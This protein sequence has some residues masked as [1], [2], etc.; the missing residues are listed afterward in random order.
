[1]INYIYLALK[2]PKHSAKHC[3]FVTSFNY[4]H[5]PMAWLYSQ[6]YRQGHRIRGMKIKD[7][8]QVYLTLDPSLQSTSLCQRGVESFA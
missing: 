1:M 8:N 2:C 6:V 5:I 3:I 4:Y 7:L